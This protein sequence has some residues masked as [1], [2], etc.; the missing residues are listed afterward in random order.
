ML[1][2]VEVR[3]SAGSPREVSGTR[4]RALLVL[5]ALRAGEVVPANWLIDQLWGERLPADAPNALQALVSRLRRAVGEPEAALEAPLGT[6]P[7]QGN[8][9]EVT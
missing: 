2:P 1:G 9:S 5:L 7:A 3:D 8:G 6:E 4:L